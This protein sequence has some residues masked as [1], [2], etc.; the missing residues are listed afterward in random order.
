LVADKCDSANF[1]KS[2][3]KIRGYMILTAGRSCIGI[4]RVW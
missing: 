4:A 3:L 2:S 1:K